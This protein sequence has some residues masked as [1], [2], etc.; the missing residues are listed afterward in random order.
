MAKEKRRRIAAADLPVIE[1]T[2]KQLYRFSTIEQAVNRLNQIRE[3]FEIASV[4]EGAEGPMVKM[5]IKGFSITDEEL[6]EG[7]LGNYA[8]IT[9][10]KVAE[11][12][13][14][15][16][17]EKVETPV[18]KH[19][20]RVRPQQK[21]PNWGH[22]VLRSL[23]KKKT[24]DSIEEAQAELELLHREY[25]EASIPGIGKLFL[26]IYEKLPDGQKGSPTRK[27]VLEIKSDD[28]GRFHLTARANTHQKKAPKKA[29]PNFTTPNAEAPVADPVRGRFTSMI[30]A[31]RFKKKPLGGGTG[32]TGGN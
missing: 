8:V 14:I 13:I 27:Y 28:K 11:G 10:R 19:P 18:A 12:H 32:N 30:E 21:H 2:L 7:A 25:P 15:L 5:W 4:Q 29:V 20:Q 24:Y 22:P 26:M 9:P 16:H 31:K 23:K 3:E 1:A 17:A 6:K